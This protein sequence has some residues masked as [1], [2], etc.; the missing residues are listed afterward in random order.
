[1]TE[2]GAGEPSD[3]PTSS[4]GKLHAHSSLVS[5]HSDS[6]HHIDPAAALNAPAIIPAEQAKIYDAGR[7]SPP[8]NL[9]CPFQQLWR[10]SWLKSRNCLA[11]CS[12]I[13]SRTFTS[14]RTKSS[15][16]C[17]K[18][19]KTAFIRL[20][21]CRQHVTFP[22][23]HHNV[24]AITDYGNQSSLHGFNQGPLSRLSEG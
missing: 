3:N 8:L 5:R 12:T 20:L 9:P 22:L 21:Q 24:S 2:H 10:H 17:R 4:K 15:R 14:P 16:R 18:W 11:V 19:L 7:E 6:P 23:F 1:V 13:R